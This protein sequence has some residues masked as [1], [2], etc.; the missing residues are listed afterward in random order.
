MRQIILDTE[1]TGLQA[2]QGHRIIEIGCLELVNRRP[3]G[4]NLHLYI[5]PQREIDEGALAVHGLTLDFLKDHPTFDK[6]SDQVLQFVTGAEVLIHNASFDVGFLDAELARVKGPKF[7]SVCAKIV[8]TVKMARELHPGKRN[9]LDAL[10]D[11]YGVSNSHRKLH[12][13]LLDAELL[14]EVYLAMTRGQNTLSMVDSEPGQGNSV[15]LKGKDWPPT[16][17]LLIKASDLERDAHQKV[18][19]GMQKEAKG[20][21]LWESLGLSK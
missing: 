21:T 17:L 4:N 9:S 8:D 6:I 15:D 10:C 14:A 3:T 11:R 13:A 16:N 20:P 18:L 1:T 2:D 19:A 7:A 5:N 12:G